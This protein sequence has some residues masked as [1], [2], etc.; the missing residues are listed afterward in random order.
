M[1]VLR[2]RGSSKGGRAR[3]ISKNPASEAQS[4]HSETIASSSSSKKT[5]AQISTEDEVQKEVV[6]LRKRG[7]SKGGRAKSK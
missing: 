3:F 7:S 2:K 5:I 4:V 1:V 6:V